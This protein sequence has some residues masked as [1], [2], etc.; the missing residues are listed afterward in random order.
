MTWQILATE[1]LPFARR[2]ARAFSKRTPSFA[3]EAEGAAML[4]LVQAAQAYRADKG[5]PFEIFAKRRILGAIQDQARTL[6]PLTRDQRKASKTGAPTVIEPRHVDYGDLAEVIAGNPLAG[7]AEWESSR[8]AAQMLRHLP[9]RLQ[10]ILRKHLLEEKSLLEIGR[11][12]GVSESRACQLVKEGTERL[13][14]TALPYE[15]DVPAARVREWKQL[16]QQ[17]RGHCLRGHALTGR[18][19]IESARKQG[20][21]ARACRRCHREATK[22]SRWNHGTQP[23]A[24]FRQPRHPLAKLSDEQ[25]K[26][27]LHA[28]VAGERVGAVARRFGVARRAVRE[29]REGRT[30]RDVPRP[31]GYVARPTP[32]G[33]LT[34]VQAQAIGRR[35]ME[36]ARAQE[37]SEEFGV[38]CATISDIR[39]GRYHAGALR[40]G[41][42]EDGRKVL[43][44]AR[45]KLT[46][47]DVR[48]ARQ[49]LANSTVA[50]VA[51]RFKV[52]F[53]A[54][55][56]LKDGVSYRSVIGPPGTPRTVSP[57]PP[58]TTIV[59]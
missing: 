45:A 53:N 7:Q 48:V 3:E 10:S 6:D 17:R 46:D 29:I 18:N 13:R 49:L 27:I 31:L 11:E 8:A 37:L 9:K 26:E 1:H 59:R 5:V 58:A 20:G 52:S 40:C 22:Q 25:V 38:S 56:A 28:L 43:R 21:F 39:R 47:D 54:M 14:L 51:R 24:A 15:K 36:G 4:G 30:Y 35:L 23:F 57:P 50:A 34:S 16:G 55:K 32:I 44:N 12:L 41:Q 2:L 19:L 42:L 33:K